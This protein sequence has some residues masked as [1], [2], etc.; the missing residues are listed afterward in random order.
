MHWLKISGSACW[1][2]SV[3]AYAQTCFTIF[4]LD[5]PPIQPWT[6]NVN[7]G[8]ATQERR[9][10]IHVNSHISDQ[11]AQLCCPIRVFIPRCI[12]LNIHRLVMR[13]VKT[14]ISLCSCASWSMS[15]LFA[16]DPMHFFWSCLTYYITETLLRYSQGPE[17]RAWIV[18]H[19][20]GVLELE[21]YDK[22]SW[23]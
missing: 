15:T 10:V 8:A 14:L 18:G 5:G 3:F 6:C 13:T 7:I 22:R 23:N 16:H 11:S 19:H 12:D 4:S 21:N 20:M 17:S 1:A 2:C 9:P